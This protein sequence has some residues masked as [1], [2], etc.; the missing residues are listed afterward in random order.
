M[1]FCFLGGGAQKNGRVPL[2]VSCLRAMLK[3][4]ARC[5]HRHRHRR[6]ATDI[7]KREKC[8]AHDN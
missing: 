4:N 3:L 8:M 7:R 5:V 2:C 6:C 1:S